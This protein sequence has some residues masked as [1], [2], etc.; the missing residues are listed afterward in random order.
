MFGHFTVESRSSCAAVF[1]NVAIKANETIKDAKI[2]NC[3]TI[4]QIILPEIKKPD[5]VL[6][7]ITYNTVKVTVATQ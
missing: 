7:I 4:Y 6:D 3:Q 1:E 5:R 2:I